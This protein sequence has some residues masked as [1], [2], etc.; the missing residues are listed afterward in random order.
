[1]LLGCSFF[2]VG[3]YPLFLILQLGDQG[4]TFMVGIISALFI[5]C[6]T[7]SFACMLAELF[8][9]PI[10]YTGFAISYNIGIAIFGGLTPMVATSLIKITGNN[11]A[12]SFYIIICALVAIS[13]LASLPETYKR[14]LK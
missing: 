7:G 11:L 12:P 4:Y 13:V 6:I 14:E 1:M 5:G 9:T 3:S 8:P 10:R 2:I